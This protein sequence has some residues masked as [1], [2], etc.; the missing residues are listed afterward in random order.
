MGDR[1][2]S[3]VFNCVHPEASVDNL[4]GLNQQKIS[5]YLDHSTKMLNHVSSSVLPA[6]RLED[7]YDMMG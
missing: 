2:K 5:R 4:V 6:P 7:L 1:I 3:L